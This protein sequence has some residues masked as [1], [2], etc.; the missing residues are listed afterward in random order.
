[1]TALWASFSR[2]SVGR[3]PLAA[4]LFA[5]A[6]LLTPAAATAQIGSDRYSSIVVEAGNGRVLSAA[7]PDELRFPASLTKMMTLYMVFEALRDRRITVHQSVPV[8]RHAASMPPTKLGLVPGTNITVEEC[9]LGMVTRSAN[10]A[11]AAIGELL[12]GDE[13]RFA[14]MMTLRARALGMTRTR[15]DNASGLPDPE[16]VTT[17]RDMATLARHLVHDFP[18]QYAYF[19]VPSF[20]FHGRT[21]T[22]HDYLLERY[23]GT[24]GIKTGYINASGFNL[25][26]SVVRDGRRLIGVV[27]G[28]SRAAGRDQHMIALLDQGYRK[29][30]IGPDSGT[31]VASRGGGFIAAAHAAPVRRPA[32]AAPAIAQAAIA[33][34]VGSGWAIQVGAFP[35]QAIARRAATKAHQR[36]AMGEVHVESVVIRRR[37]H[38]R[39]QLDG[40]RHAEAVRGCAIL[41]RHKQPCLLL[42]PDQLASR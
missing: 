15:F 18:R 29:L 3:A 5:A 42:R 11:A 20:R 31:M 23:S 4:L 17:A 1:M 24:D 40:L 35:K 19:S 33:A 10:D 2:L 38:W 21:I 12:G 7:N 13:R 9:I 26:T 16:Q 22:G 36:L 34:P 8:S 41:T 37:T 27:F 6:M 32:A 25:V 30:D 14:Q 28:A 39:A